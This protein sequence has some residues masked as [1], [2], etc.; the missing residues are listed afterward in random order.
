LKP[1]A[2]DFTLF[3][4]PRAKC[5]FSLN[6]EAMQ[7]KGALLFLFFSLR[8]KPLLDT[9]LEKTEEEFSNKRIWAI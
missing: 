3:L 4:E 2:Q 1:G 9:D 7:L 6:L 8:P 5:R